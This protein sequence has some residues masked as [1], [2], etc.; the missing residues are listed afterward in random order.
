MR[1]LWQ[2]KIHFGEDTT[3]IQTRVLLPT[4]GCGE[5]SASQMKKDLLLRKHPLVAALFAVAA[6][7]AVLFAL[8]GLTQL[9]SQDRVMGRVEVAGVP[10]GGLTTEEA[11]ATLLE[12]EDEYQ[13]RV[14]T[15]QLLGQPVILDASE[16]GLRLDVED[17]LDQAMVI[18]REGNFPYQFLFWLKHIFSTSEIEIS[19]STSPTAVEAIFDDWDR[20]VIGRPPTHGSITVEDGQLV[21]THPVAGTGIDRDR[22]ADIISDTLLALEPVSVTI[23]TADVVPVLTDEDI[24]N[25]YTI[26]E[27]LTGAPISLVSDGNPLTFTS[28]Q[29]LEAY[30]GTTVIEGTP[31]VVHSFD[32]ETIGGFID[33]QRSQFQARPVDARFEING[34]DI[35]IIQGRRGTRIDEA[36][37]AERLLNAGMTANRRGT[38]PI[39][40]GA[41]PRVTTQS[42]QDMGIKHLVSQFTTYHD[43]CQ[44]RVVNIRLMAE[45]VSM[46]VIPPGGRFD[47]NAFVGPR[48]EAKGYL[49]APTIIGFELTDTI[50]GGVSQ[51]ATTLYNAVFWGG[52]EDIDHRPH[53]QW[54]SR[55]P[56]GIEATINWG[57]PELIFGNNTSNHILI[58]TRTT[59]TSIT[60]R[61]FGD[62]DGRIVKGE[63]SGGRTRMN[64][65]AAGG[66]QAR[67]VHGEVSERFDVRTPPDPQ[68]R[69]DDTYGVN[70]ISTVQSARDGWSVTVTRVITRGGEQV[71]RRQWTVT[72]RP[73]QTIYVVH[74]CK[75]PGTSRACPQPPTT[76]T[77]STS[78]TTT[79]PGGGDDGD[80]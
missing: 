55:Y 5:S 45:T 44:D 72:Y 54:F 53:T 24:D 13:G 19:G 6:G 9:T 70:Q 64:V 34:D 71:G 59:G 38:L 41:E 46:H 11:R 79:L 68:Y 18:G 30:R 65:V 57:G 32:V 80:D 42:L 3:Q 37:A 48:T 58:H 8:Y 12:V 35:R 33:P 78:T 23:P 73:Q 20:R 26:A 15:F 52:Y 62:N 10:I 28:E 50:G 36:I 22:A 67:H 21:A 7:F 25:A 29:L 63:Q 2:G 66:P 43:C 69:G 61:I 77:T 51:F 1:S 40:E 76:T 47:L 16:S 4:D 14:L 60:V 75:V 17:I 27:Q 31:G 74:P 39:V 49:P 56:E